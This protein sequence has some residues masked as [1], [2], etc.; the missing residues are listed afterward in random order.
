[1]AARLKV[2]HVIT[3]LILGGAQENTLFTVEGLNKDEYEVTLATGPAIGPEGSLVQRAGQADINLV[4][5]PQM[6]RAVN[7]VLDL[8]S[9]FKLYGLIKKNKY[10]IVH[11]HSS[12]AGILGRWAAKLAKTR[13][14]IHTIHGLPFYKYQNKSL[15]WLYIFLEKITAK[16][17][18]K[19]IVVADAMTQQCLDVK[20]AGAD[21]FITI[22]SGIEIEKFANSTIDIRQLKVRLGIPP[23][24]LVIGKIARLSPMKGHE[25]LIEAAREV[26]KKI[27]Q[28]RFLLVGD[29]ILREDLMNQIQQAGLKNNFVFTGLIAPEKIPEVIQAMDILVHVSLR[30]GLARA[31]PQALASAKPVISFDV[32]GA[33]EVV[34]ND[35]TGY[36]IPAKDK[37]LLAEKMI[38]LL[39]NP[40]TACKM[41]SAGQ[42]LVEKSF[43]VENMVSDIE[44]V[45]KKAIAG[46]I[47][48]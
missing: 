4:I 32:D 30:E 21:K 39:S 43:K 17:T 27:P 40:E 10:A 11:T 2:L 18:H 9:F 14:I 35:K 6:R 5:I 25:Y 46:D 19:I 31:L 36:L 1:M 44:E 8:I 20:I 22:H 7:P 15:N 12:K 29:G 38:Y 24:A 26:V 13:V 37:T 45:Y 47:L 33:R 28:T 42:E 48:C 34:I 41:G 23:E 16:I 3:R